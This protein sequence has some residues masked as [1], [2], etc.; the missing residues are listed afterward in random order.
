MEKEGNMFF[1]D[2]VF[3][4]SREISWLAS[5]GEFNIFGC[6][7]VFL[8]FTIKIILSLFNLLTLLTLLIKSLFSM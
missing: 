8:M 3:F 7:F 2:K 6:V 1:V 4:K 5:F